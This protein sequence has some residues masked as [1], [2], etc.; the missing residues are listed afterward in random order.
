MPALDDIFSW[1][2]ENPAAAVTDA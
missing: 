2:G 1:P